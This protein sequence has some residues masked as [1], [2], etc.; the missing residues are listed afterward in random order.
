MAGTVIAWLLNGNTACARCL[1]I[2]LGKINADLSVFRRAIRDSGF[3]ELGLAGSHAEA[4][5]GL[6]PLHKDPFDRMLVAQSL[7]EP[8]ILLTADQAMLACSPLVRSVG[9]L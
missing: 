5:L 6:P 1:S 3:S 9:A 7:S 8:M 4:L 2:G